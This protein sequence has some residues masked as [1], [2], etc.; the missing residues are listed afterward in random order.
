MFALLGGCDP[1]EYAH[2][3]DD[4]PLPADDLTRIT[5]GY[6]QLKDG[7]L[8]P[9]NLLDA[10]LFRIIHQGLANVLYEFLHDLAK[11]SLPKN[12][13]LAEARKRKATLLAASRGSLG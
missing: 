10:D 8:R 9:L 1:D 11:P 4:P 5:G 12:S 2:G 7:R 13:C 3:V 6:R